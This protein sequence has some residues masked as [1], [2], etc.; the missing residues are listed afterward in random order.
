MIRLLKYYLIFGAWLLVIISAPSV[1]AATDPISASASATATIPETTFSTGDTVAPTNPILI[2]PPDGT[3]TND[4]RTEFVWRSSTDPNGNTVIYTLYLNG[5]ATYLGISNIGNSTG[6]GYAARID[7]QEIKLQPTVSLL[8]GEY[9][10]HVTASDPSGNTSHSTTWHFTIDTIA[11]IIEVTDIDIYHDLLLSSNHPEAFENNNFD[12]SGPKDVNFIIR[13]EPWSTVT[14]QFM[15]SDNLQIAQSSW[16]VGSSGVIYPY[17]HL[18]IGV[19]HLI[20]TSLDHG[21]NISA[22]PDINL[23]ISQTQISVTLPALP[24]SS[25]TPIIT[26]PYTPLSLASL[27]ATIY[28]LSNTYDLAAIMYVSLATLL[29]L[30]LIYLWRSRYNLL[31]LTESGEPISSAVIYHSIPTTRTS[32]SPIYVTKREPISYSLIKNDHGKLYIPHLS[33]YS[34]F[35]VRQGNSTYIFSLCVRRPTYT[36]VLG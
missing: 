10:W 28:S 33:R 20:V 31:L 3:V 23:T 30:L 1:R 19:Y 16:P 9:N 22:L 24:G 27:P 36:I 34:T 14:L 7:G 35:T 25:P 4:N 17:Q 32:Y 21:G 5:V 18:A 13:C 2:R 11:P 26:I 8:D 15:D 6:N 29:I 12:I